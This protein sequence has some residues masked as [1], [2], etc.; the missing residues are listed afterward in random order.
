MCANSDTEYLPDPPATEVVNSAIVLF[1]LALPLQDVKIQESMLEQL[2]SFLSAKSLT[3]DPGRK[4]AITVNISLAILNMIKVGRSEISAAPGELRSPVVERCLDD[5][6]RVSTPFLGFT[7]GILIF[8]RHWS[9]TQ[10]NV[11]AMPQVKLS[12]DFVTALEAPLP[13]VLYR[14]W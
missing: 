10:I 7:V 8:Y 14:A 11:S 3:R 13:Q 6:L 1:A 9:Q 2:H 5:L 4:A 12:G